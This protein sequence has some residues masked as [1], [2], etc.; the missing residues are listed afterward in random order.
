MAGTCAIG[1][2]GGFRA[3]V[4][5]RE[6]PREAWRRRGA[7]LVKL[8]AL[9]PAHR[10]HRGQVMDVLWPELEPKAA[11]ANLRKAVHFARRALGSGDAIEADGEMLS[12][13]PGGG[14]EI[15]VERFEA[16]ARDAI[17]SGP[18]ACALAAEMFAGELLPE[19]RYTEWTEPT[20]ERV[21]L[22]YLEL[23]R[24]SGA[25]ERI[26]EFDRANEEAHRA[27]MRAHLEAG[28][29]GAAIRQ[30]E[31]LREVLRVDLGVGPDEETVAL[32]E[33]ALA[34]DGHA[35]PTPAER[36][37]GLIARGLVHWNRQELDAAERI[38][39]EA[40]ALAVEQE[41]G[42]DLGEA[43]ALLALVSWARGRWL[44]R[45]RAE[46]LESVRRTPELAR[47]VLDS[48]LCLA[49]FSLY[50]ADWQKSVVPLAGE[51]LAAAEA[52]DSIPGQAL[53]TLILGE[54]ELFSGRLESAEERLTR[55][56]DL[57]R[58]ADMAGGQILALQRLAEAAIAGGRRRQA[59]GLLRKA[60][61]LAEGSEL[62]SHLLVRNFAVMVAAAG[63]EAT[64]LKILDEAEAVLGARELCSPCSIGFRVAAARASAQAQDVGRGRRSLQEAERLAGLWQGGPWVA[65]TWE[66]RGLL[67]LAEGD[68]DQGAALLR[69]AADLF[70]QVGR[71]LD[72]ARCL[73]YVA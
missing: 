23:L 72:E 16:A 20:R 52:A 53:V 35:P 68:A 19:D 6:I 43:C 25:W 67:R 38:A 18:E 12:L 42:R 27:L 62:V 61:R 45:F 1:L 33:E 71:P 11:A 30:F 50:G 32:F 65:A 24:A 51:L 70:A 3:T 5:G 22:Q 69:E 63:T 73:G 56:L 14:L 44:D 31:R 10:L 8:L 7:D 36:V 37:R 40:R 54:A 55:A 26:L 15:D 46:F 9:A 34:M 49:E 17:A 57:H 2:L 21:R 64:R 39:E 58:E 66:V 13:W 28:N 47:W 41:L 59:G 60:R 29:R 48:Q 4:E